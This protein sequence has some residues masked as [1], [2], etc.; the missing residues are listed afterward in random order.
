MR[1]DTPVVVLTTASTKTIADDCLT[2][3]DDFI[4]K[5]MNWSYFFTRFGLGMRNL[6][7]PDSGRWYG[8]T[9]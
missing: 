3:T 1:K 8:R 4:V 6:G 5:A 7:D 9:K 2:Y